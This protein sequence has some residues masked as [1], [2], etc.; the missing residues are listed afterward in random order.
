MDSLRGFWKRCW[1]SQSVTK[2]LGRK[3][4]ILCSLHFFFGWEP[5]FFFGFRSGLVW[6]GYFC[7]C[8]LLLS[9]FCLR[10][11]VGVRTNGWGLALYIIRMRYVYGQ[12]LNGLFFL[13]TGETSFFLSFFGSEGGSFFVGYGELIHLFIL[14]SW[15][16][17]PAGHLG[18]TLVH[19]LSVSPVQFAIPWQTMGLTIVNA[20]MH[21]FASGDRKREGYR[22]QF[23][24]TNHS[25]KTV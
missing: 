20:E 16:L 22:T 8:F 21:K 5:S 2:I 15:K 18:L 4:S 3:L 10:R 12:N 25:F 23:T 1:N 9:S 24:P 6:E 11:G 17:A 13:H 14:S 7:F 19:F